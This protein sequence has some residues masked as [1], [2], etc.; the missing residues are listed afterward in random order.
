MNTREYSAWVRHPAGSQSSALLYPCLNK[1]IS[2]WD[3]AVPCRK[4]VWK[5][6]ERRYRTRKLS[7][8]TFLIRK[9]R[10]RHTLHI[11]PVS[12]IHYTKQNNKNHHKGNTSACCVLQTLLWE[13]NVQNR[14]LST[15]CSSTCPVHIHIP[16][17]LRKSSQH[18]QG[19]PR[20]VMGL[21]SLSTSQ[22]QQSA[23]QNEKQSHTVPT[24]SKS[25]PSV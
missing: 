6:R 14:L 23:P 25:W 8:H 20:K 13:R 9:R 4:P 22:T 2:P 24:A 3:S 18:W 10:L 15:W 19:L 21:R 12:Q 11:N 7:E 17:L 5:K 16:I 1:C